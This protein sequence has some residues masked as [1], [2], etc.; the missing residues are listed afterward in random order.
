MDTAK[1][2]SKEQL[3]I[4]R[5]IRRALHLEPGDKIKF[6][7]EGQRITPRAIEVEKCDPRTGT[8]ASSRGE[9]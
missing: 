7:F 1:L 4:P 9:A 5:K 2:S 6:T 3:V 8:D